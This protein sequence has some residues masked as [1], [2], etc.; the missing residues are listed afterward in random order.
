MFDNYENISTQYTPS[1]LDNCPKKP[2][3]CNPMLKPLQPVKPYE[4]YNAEG[5]LIGYWWVY[6]DTINLEF[7]LS[8]YVTIDDDD[9]YVEIRDFIKD[10]EIYVQLYNFRHEQI[11][12][13]NF[14][15]SDY[16]EVTYSV[17]KKVN[18]FTQGI[19]YVLED[20]TYEPVVLPR[21]FNKDT[22]YYKKDDV[23]IIFPIDKKLS[24]QMEKGTYY[25]SISIRND[26]LI[27]TIFYQ[28]ECTLVVK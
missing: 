12:S 26:D 17:A 15:G 21:D 25:C 24:A 18:R 10:K 27:S 11:A 6:G 14:N 7:D 19:Y 13:M 16:Q 22:I 20:D 1:N 8:G 23:E 9:T 5:Q 3:K 2:N 28:E 4:E